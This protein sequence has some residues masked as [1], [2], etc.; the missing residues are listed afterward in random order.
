MKPASGLTKKQPFKKKESLQD[1]EDL[2]DLEDINSITN[3]PKLAP[4]NQTNTLQ[5]KEDYFAEAE[6]K[7]KT[8][9]DGK[10]QDIELDFLED[11]LSEDKDNL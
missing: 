6:K 8:Q 9:K 7:I 1:L 11:A 5:L 3:P 10:K 2:G 4:K